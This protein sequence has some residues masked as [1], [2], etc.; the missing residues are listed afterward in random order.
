MKKLGNVK[1]GTKL[2]IMFLAMGILP[3]AV[4]GVISVM[5]ASSALEK[6]AFAQ[7][8][9]LR[10]V[11][12]NQTIRYFQTIND[13]I[14]TFSQD[15]MIVDAMRTFRDFFREFRD[16][17]QISATE[18]ERMRR[19]LL[20]YYTGEFSAEYKKQNEKVQI[21]Y[22][23]I[24]PDTFKDGI[25]LDTST[26]E[27]YY[28]N[29]KSDFMTKSMVNVQYLSFEFPE[30]PEESEESEESVTQ[31]QKNENASDETSSNNPESVASLKKDQKSI[32]DDVSDRIESLLKDKRLSLRDIAQKVADEE[33]LAFRSVYKACLSLKNQNKAISR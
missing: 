20:T 31:D 9:S 22:V 26:I 18:M 7:L 24:S 10:D 2:M 11:K 6:Q 16:E 32:V 25:S 3:F 13:Q 8:E 30:E 1:I 12:K 33:G 5:K 15:Q 29:N 17:R 4:V 19:E 21:S 27:E 14:L 23:F 28:E